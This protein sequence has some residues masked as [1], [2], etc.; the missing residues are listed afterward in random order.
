[1]LTLLTGLFSTFIGLQGIR[2]YAYCLLGAETNSGFCRRR[3]AGKFCRWSSLLDL[4]RSGSR[5]QLE[6]LTCTRPLL[7]RRLVGRFRSISVVWNDGS[8]FENE[9]EYEDTRVDHQGETGEKRVRMVILSATLYFLTQHPVLAMLVL[10]IAGISLA[11]V[12]G[13]RGWYGLIIPRLV[14]QGR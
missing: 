13:H 3:R 2:I 6:S 11:K 7:E 8:S 9:R 14:A 12:R 4:A 1:M 5:T 10:V